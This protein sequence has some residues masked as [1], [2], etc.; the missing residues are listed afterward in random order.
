MQVGY[1]GLSMEA[2]AARAGVTKPTI[3]LRFPT[4]PVLVFEAVFGKTKSKAMPDTGNLHDDLNQAYSWAV[5]EFAAPEARVALPGLLTEIAANPELAQLI[6]SR[7]IEPEYG[8]VHGLLERARGRGDVRDSADL[9]LVIDAFLGTALARALVV[10]RPIDRAF[11]DD[12]VD[13]LINGL[14]A[15]PPTPGRQRD[16]PSS[17]VTRAQRSGDRDT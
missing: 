11:G 6:R 9:T 12:L 2:V 13:L 4:K 7:L 1:T 16:R 14:A 15:P 8:R 5:D 3:Y 17:R 10:D